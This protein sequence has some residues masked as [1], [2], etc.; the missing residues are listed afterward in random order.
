MQ[1]TLEAI[2]GEN[3]SAAIKMRTVLQTISTI[4]DVIDVSY[5][6]NTNVAL[7]LQQ[8]IWNILQ[9]VSSLGV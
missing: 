6:L 5:K 7:K 8:Q 4:Q 1:K 9:V 3:R 2:I